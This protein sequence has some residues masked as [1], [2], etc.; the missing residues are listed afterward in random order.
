MHLQRR[1]RIEA[2]LGRCSR[3]RCARSA[4]GACGSRAGRGTRRGRRSG[5]AACRSPPRTRRGRRSPS[6]HGLRARSA[7]DAGSNSGTTNACGRVAR[8]SEHPLDVVGHGDAAR[9]IETVGQP[10]AATIFTGSFAGTNMRSCWSRPVAAVLEDGVAGAV[11]DL[12]RA[13]AGCGQRRR[14][15][16]RAGLLVAQIQRLAGLVGA[17]G[18]SATASADSRRCSRPRCSRRRD[19]ETTKPQRGLAITF[20]H[21]AGVD[22]AGIEMDRRTRGR[23]E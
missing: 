22:S 2:G 7:S 18:R 5:R 4:A 14:R 10:G 3:G 13:G 8:R 6:F 1:A 23:P 11:P 20:T 12:I 9:A 21:G 19:S 16:H 15:P 17:P